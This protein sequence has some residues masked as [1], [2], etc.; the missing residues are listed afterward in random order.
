MR[1]ENLSKII[2]PLLGQPFECLKMFSTCLRD[3]QVNTSYGITEPYLKITKRT[4]SNFTGTYIT[5]SLY[6]IRVRGAIHG[7]P[8][9]QLSCTLLLFLP[10]NNFK[11]FEGYDFHSV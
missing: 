9:R 3:F 1:I 8:L 4:A 11:H 2:G 7:T 10:L 5:C 6:I